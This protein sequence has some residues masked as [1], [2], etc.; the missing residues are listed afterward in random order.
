[1]KEAF[2]NLFAIYSKDKKG[3]QFVEQ[4]CY[5]LTREFRKL[6]KIIK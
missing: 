5:F 1:M 6:L 2:A 3:W 4:K